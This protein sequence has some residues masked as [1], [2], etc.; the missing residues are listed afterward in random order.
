MHP[1]IT[2]Y[3]IPLFLLLILADNKKLDGNIES[4]IQ[5]DHRHNFLQE[6]YLTQHNER[7]RQK[8]Q[9]TILCGTEHTTRGYN[10]YIELCKRA[11]GGQI[12]SWKGKLVC[13]IRYVSYV[14]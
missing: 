4:T 9:T 1:R 3:N 11:I 12:T 8:S 13:R 5:T 6:T 2:N 7:Q 14:R 10:C